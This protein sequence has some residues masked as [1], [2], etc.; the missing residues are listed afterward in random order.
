MKERKLN[1]DDG[2]LLALYSYGQEDAPGE[3]RVVVVGG[4]FLTALIYRPFSMALAAELD[5]ITGEGRGW[6]VDVYDRRGRGGSSEQPDDYS[7]ETEISDLRLVL[8]TTGAHNIFGHSLGGAV[9][10]NAA[11]RFAGTPLEPDRLAVYDAAVNLDGDMDVSWLPSFEKAVND[12][13]VRRALARLRKGMQPASTLSRV[14]EPILVGLMAVVSRTKVNKMFGQL[15]P[16]GV[17]ELKA[18]IGVSNVVEDFA[19]LPKTTRFFVGA[20]S[21]S[22]Y[23]VTAEKLHQSVHGSGLQVSPKGVHGSIPAAVKVLVSDIAKYFAA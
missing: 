14:P 6:A 18:A 5:K 21:P 15:M 10:L 11:Q 17:G 23:K 22:Y 12:G 8:E 7:M 2:G 20:K 16:S 9:A 3:R 13:D 19:V 4:A 1:T